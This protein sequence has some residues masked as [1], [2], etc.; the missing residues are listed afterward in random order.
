MFARSLTRTSTRLSVSAS[1]SLFRTAP[2]K[3]LRY[4]QTPN[5]YSPIAFSRTM[6]TQTQTLLRAIAEDHQEMYAFYDKYVQSNGDA[7]AQERWSR[8]LI[9]EVARHAIGEELVVY[10]LME[11]HLGAEGKK[12]ADEDRADHQYVKNQL[13]ALEKLS[14]GTP[15]HAATLKDVMDHL[16]PH[17]D[18]E[19]T[20]DLPLLEKAIGQASSMEAAGSFRRTKKFV[21]TRSH[22]SAPNKP[23]FETL[24]G[25]M[26]APM[27][28]LKDVFAKFPKEEEVDKVESEA[29]KN[30]NVRN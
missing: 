12:L 30:V 6:A 4:T 8:Q 9:W 13:Y 27:D 22:P 18:S 14:A 11:K 16:H 3:P 17:N 10:P 24:A 21:P 28:K 20:H 29:K 1:K 25:L 26:A 5:A 15:E 2:T 7:D 19:E 23:P